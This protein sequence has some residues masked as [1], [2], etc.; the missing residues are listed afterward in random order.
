MRVY[1]W[2]YIYFRIW[3][4]GAGNIIIAIIGNI[5]VLVLEGLIV[6]IQ[7]LRLEY[8]ELFSRFYDGSGIEFKPIKTQL[9]E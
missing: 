2:Q 1:V 8:Y 6:G 9:E 3:H 5:I 4:H 7:T